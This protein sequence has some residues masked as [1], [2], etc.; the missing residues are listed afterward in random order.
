MDRVSE[1]EDFE[2]ESDF[3]EKIC[4]TTDIVVGENHRR[5]AVAH[6]WERRKNM[7]EARSERRDE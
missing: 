4:D 1:R 5:I 2:V 3:A 7:L 6:R